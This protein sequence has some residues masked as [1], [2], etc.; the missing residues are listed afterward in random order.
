MRS[1]RG[2]GGPC[3]RGRPDG[4]LVHLQDCAELGEGLGADGVGDGFPAAGFV[5]EA[6]VGELL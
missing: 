5:E 2:R 4:W 3:G 1:P 6:G